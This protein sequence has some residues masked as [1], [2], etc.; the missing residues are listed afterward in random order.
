[1]MPSLVATRPADRVS[2]E[3]LI[4]EYRRLEACAASR[5]DGPG[6]E[7]MFGWDLEYLSFGSLMGFVDYILFRGMNDVLTD[8]PQPVILDCGANVGYTV[9]HYKRLCPDARITAFEPDP[10]FVPVLRRNLERNGA[11]DVEIVEAAV[12]TS[13]GHMPWRTVGTDGSRVVVPD[14][15]ETVPSCDVATVDLLGYLD[16][17]IDLLKVDIEGAEFAVVPHLAPRLHN[18]RNILVECHLSDQ[19]AHVALGGVLTTLSAAG[20][21]VGLNSYGPW[22]DLTRRH[23]PAAF[24]AEQYV[25]L[26]GW[27][28]DDSR[29]VR[30][31]SY[32]PYVGIGPGRDLARIQD[33]RSRQTQTIADIATGR[34]VVDVRT[35]DGPFRR[36]GGHCWTWQPRREIPQGDSGVS[37]D[38]SLLILENERALGPAHA[39]H[40]DIRTNGGGRYSHWGPQLYWSTSDN[41]DPNTNG[42]TYRAV[43]LRTR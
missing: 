32:L 43:C 20:F 39:V 16:R 26:A 41:S 8:R 9:L 31:P 40:D 4:A 17:D 14:V 2:P 29:V 35:L 21:Q 36:E 7:V 24:H 1:M 5:G 12:W 34:T 27:R 42:R 33:E 3:H 38:S 6:R 18:V 28:T 25:L 22:R 23:I 15:S 19:A 10:R 30:E 37:Q 11:R 13:R